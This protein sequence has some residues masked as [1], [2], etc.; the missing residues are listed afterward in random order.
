MRN[1][2]TPKHRGGKRTR[3]GE[4]NTRQPFQKKKE[5]SE[6]VVL[7]SLS[8]EK[9]KNNSLSL[10]DAKELKNRNHTEAQ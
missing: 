3:I 8:H 2:R 6:H 1:H 5:T 10:D 9:I 4:L 7:I